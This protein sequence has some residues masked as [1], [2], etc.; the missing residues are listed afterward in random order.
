MTNRKDMTIKEWARECST[1]EEV[2]EMLKYFFKG[3]IQ[4]IFEVAIEKHL[5]YKKHS[6]KSNRLVNKVTCS[7]LAVN[8]EG[9]KKFQASGLEKTKVFTSAWGE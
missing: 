1:V 3:I 9:I 5:N 4:K 7:V 2:H 6:P 8:M